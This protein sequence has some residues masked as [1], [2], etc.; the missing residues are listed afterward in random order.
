MYN[1]CK[2]CNHTYSQTRLDEMGK[3]TE[4]LCDEYICAMYS[5]LKVKGSNSV[6][7]CEK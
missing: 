2:V 1:K 7:Y 3:V 6:K 4:I 5:K